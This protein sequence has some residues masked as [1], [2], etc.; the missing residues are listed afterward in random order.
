MASNTNASQESSQLDVRAALA[1]RSLIVIG[2][3]G[4]LGKVWLSLLLHRYPEVGTIYVMV[5]ARK[6]MTA[7]ERFWSEIAPSQVFDPIRDQRPGAGY[8]NFLREKIVAFAGDVS[9]KMI[10]ADQ[11]T[12]ERMKV[13]RPAIVNVAGVVDFNPPLD[14]ALSVNAFGIKNIIE[15]ARMLGNVPVMHTS[16]CFVVGRR[17]GLIYERDPLEYPFPRA[18][19]LDASHWDPE[20]EIA[21]CV[22][23]VEYTKRRVE[24][25]PRQSHLLDEA[26]K[27][28]RR[29]VEPL[30][31]PALADELEK[32]KRNYVRQQLVTAGKERA[33]FWGWPNIY[34]YT[35]SIGEQVLLRSG[36]PACIVRPAIV[37]SAVEF[38][39]QGWCEGIQTSTPIMYLAM[40][41]LQNIPVGDHC[42]YDLIPVD[43]C[44]AAMV[45]QLAALLQGTHKVVYQ[46]CTGDSNPLKTKRAGELIAL[47]KRQR[48]IDKGDGNQLLNFVQAHTEP[49]VVS[50]ATYERFGAPALVRLTKNA[51][52]VLD[53]AKATPLAGMTE[54]LRPT[55]ASANRQASNISM[56]VG[57]FV[58]FITQFEYRFSAKNTREL[59]RSLTP[60]DQQRLPWNPEEINW[61]DY[62]LDIH[63]T[64]FN[65]WAEPLL[66]EKLQKEI[67]PLRR[68]QNLVEMLLD[69]ADR[70]EHSLAFQRLEG[71]D[72]TRVSYRDVERQSAAA[73]A[74]LHALG[75]RSGDK[76]ALG[77]RNH[78]DWPIAYFG[79][80]RA[81]AVAVP[82]D[83]AATGEQVHN[84]L[85]AA[86]AKV[87]IF[88]E[89]MERPSPGLELEIVDLH[90]IAA[91]PGDDESS[92]APTVTINDSD[93]ASII[94]TSGTTGTPKGVMLTHENFTAL[95]AALAPVFPLRRSDRLLSVLPLH[96]TFEFTCGMLLPVSRGARVV[97]L[98]EVVADRLSAGLKHGSITAM[99]GVPAL[100]QLLERRILTTVEE[101]G[102]MTQRI[103]DVLLDFNR[104]MG[105]QLGFDLGKVLFGSVHDGLGGNLRTLISGGSALPRDVHDTFSG[106]GLHLAEGY[107][108]TEASP[109]LTVA[110]AGPKNRPGQV[111]KPIPGVEVKILNPNDEGV[112][113]VAARGPNVMAGYAGDP[114]A[115]AAVLQDGWLKTGD[116]GRLDKKGRLQIVG[117]SK[118]VIVTS[119]GENVYPDDVETSVGTPK[120]VKE[121]CVFGMPERAGSSN[122]RVAC[123]AVPD[124]E[125]RPDLSRAALQQL[126]HE[127]LREAFDKLPRASRPTI[128]HL[129][130]TAL[131]RTGTRK[132]KRP[133]VRRF[134]ESLER[135]GTAIKASEG[136]ASSVVR[137]AL[138]SVT[139][140]KPE[141][142]R[143]EMHLVNDLGL[144]S[145]MVAELQTALDHYLR[146]VPPEQVARAQTVGE[147]EALVRSASKSTRALS[148]TASV[149]DDEKDDS[150]VLPDVV[151]D[152]TRPAFANTQAAFFTRVMKVRVTGSGYIPH[153]RATLV[154]ANH[155][156]HLDAG[157][158]RHALGSYGKE[159]VTLAA[160]DYFFENKWTRAW[161][162]NFTYVMPLDRRSGLRKALLQAGEQLDAGQVV[163]IFP[164]GTRSPDGSMREFGAMV[165]NLVLKHHVDLL[166]IYLVGTHAAFPKG[167]KIP[168]PRNR[169]VG[170]RIGP[171]L[172]YEKLALL[173]KG[174]KRADS[175]REVARLA[176]R[177]V[178]SLRD[179]TVLDLDKIVRAHQEGAAAPEP[180]MSRGERLMDH[181]KH[182]FVARS[183][184]KPVSFYFSLGDDA[185]GKWCLNIEPIACT[186]NAGK[187]PS[188]TADCV[189]KTSMD[190]FEKIVKE[191]Y[192]PS[193][194]EFVSGKVKSNDIKLL[195]VFQKAFNL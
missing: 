164:E 101:R 167:A 147:I 102:D 109:V 130:D 46:M 180:E 148:R 175:Y 22:D 72:L 87:A 100:W 173:T 18:D 81:G 76:V 37:E 40:Q 116:L 75:V 56:V 140:R 57:E 16:T 191:R 5:R 50:L 2:A 55:L 36:L 117:R 169:N 9:A 114:E 99:V 112:G 133:E 54:S 61:R 74:R 4:F 170:A 41:G 110:K 128:I 33:Q 177:A 188:G 107:G 65:K 48:F 126:A 70:M 90:A 138:A 92:E 63:T 124:F 64:G 62:W 58:P 97:Y 144:D 186:F 43:L 26:K 86:Q 151:K 15:L 89:K 80:M 174:M 155:A 78:P 34:T 47:S 185:D 120:Y 136:S 118:D 31:G 7:Q 111:G 146:D 163:L 127:A 73:A 14:E 25:A 59:M 17:D 162:E 195:Q 184:D 96:H 69:V 160:A 6:G 142:I 8:E 28:L 159:M 121:L 30:R 129:T 44:A 149:E 105:K 20:R 189:L 67:K 53:A 166:P 60:A 29:R 45:A 181:L 190:I 42:H 137:S 68:H 66:V 24:E 134:V 139:R 10:G 119:N 49:A 183:V 145:L 132:V 152:F 38:P 179:K 27:G 157:L 194:A 123:L 154:I 91:M 193:V 94:Y 115:T 176:Q 71:E 21:E 3:T 165:G 32:V 39:L 19:E 11:E 103:F 172:E 52:G 82:I 93:V 156:S 84:I 51:L 106:L 150:I 131:P 125:G 13:D 1:G 104:N 98:D 178:E 88:D 161:F 83:H 122:E 23:V 135:A 153:N 171:P 77:A 182:R 79:V 192:T 12:L 187:P 168:V 143:L 158:V 85:R 35:K 141:E 95:I 113:E 108:L